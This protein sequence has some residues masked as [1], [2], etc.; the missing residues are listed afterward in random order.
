MQTE[1]KSIAAIVVELAAQG[2]DAGRIADIAISTWQGVYAALSRIIGH[3][4]IAA[5]YKRSLYLTRADYPWL[6]AEHEDGLEP[7]KF[8]ALHTALLQQTSSNAAA[9]HVALLQI[10]HDL[11]VSLIGA[12]LSERLLRSVWDKHSTGL[13]AQDSTQ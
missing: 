8:T 12:S 3:R 9:A 10:F 1:T 11:L 5:L 4:G 6:T 2:A 13:A 7:G